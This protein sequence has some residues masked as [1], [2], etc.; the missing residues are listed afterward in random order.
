MGKVAH[1]SKNPNLSFSFRHRFITC[2]LVLLT[3]RPQ[4]FGTP[5]DPRMEEVASAACKRRQAKVIG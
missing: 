2:S 5:A 1:T 3:T 4:D